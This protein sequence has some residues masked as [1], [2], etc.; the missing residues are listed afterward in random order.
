M[1]PD[2][3][4][5]KIL[6]T[7][8]PRLDRRRI[9]SRDRSVAFWQRWSKAVVRRRWLAA[10]AA[11][12][13]LGALLVAATS[14]HM[15]NADPDTIAKRGPAKQGLVALE[16]SGI[17]KGAI[18]PVETLVPE[19]DAQTVVS[20]QARV[21]GVH[22]VVAPSGPEW[23]RGGDAIVVTV[24]HAGDE[25]QAGRDTVQGVRDAAHAASAQARTGGTGP[26]NADFID[27]VY[28]SF[29]L[30]IALISLL[31]FVL[32]ARAFRSL[33]LP[34]KAIVLNVLSVG[35]AWGVL[36]LTRILF[37]GMHVKN[38]AGDR[39]LIKHRLVDKMADRVA[40]RWDA[41]SPEERERFRQRLREKIGFDA[42]AGPSHAQ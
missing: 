5:T 14:L 6:A 27:A 21:A 16:R 32:L 8:G 4:R 11:L 20:A 26:L 38:G 31:T 15:G 3:R 37:G 2:P 35:A 42:G 1:T 24:P 33:L 17:G 41:M 25:A 12:T 18:V 19:S 13:I 7:I 28:G 39:R 23:R 9:R 36:T 22:G 10:L 40:E 34:L 29:P 30:M